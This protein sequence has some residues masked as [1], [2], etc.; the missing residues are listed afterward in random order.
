MTKRAPKPLPPP[1]AEEREK[2]RAAAAAL[3][4]AI[5]DP[6]TMGKPASTHLYYGGGRG[7]YL[8]TWSGLPG[9]ARHT[10]NSRRTYSHT[11]LPGWEYVKK[12]IL[13]ELIPDLEKLAETGERPSEVTS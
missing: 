11:L 9:F 8:D 5:A 10:G 4:L 12:E 3:R 6:S 13:S 2:A 1:T 7:E